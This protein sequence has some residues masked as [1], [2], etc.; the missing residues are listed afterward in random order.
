LNAIIAARIV[1]RRR[2]GVRAAD[3]RAQ[4]R[5]LRRSVLRLVLAAVREVNQG[6]APAERVRVVGV[7]QPV[8]WGAIRTRADYELFQASLAGRD[9]FLYA[10]IRERMH[11]FREGEKAFFLTNT[12]HAYMRL[13][14]ADGR[15]Q[16]NAA[17]FFALRPGP[18]LL[19]AAP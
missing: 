18:R 14:D 19:G 4:L 11:G 6:L 13:R 7:D 8:W 5:E 1:V 3:G 9:F 15:P 10:T 12:R 17:G 16:L 2:W